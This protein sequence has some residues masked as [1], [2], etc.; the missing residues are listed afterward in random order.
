MKSFRCVFAVEILAVVLYTSHAFLPT[1]TERT[2]ASQSHDSITE[3]SIL[4]IVGRLLSSP[5]AA[6]YLPENR[7]ILASESFTEALRKLT[8]A[9]AW[10]DF[11][12]TA[13]EDPTVHFND[14][15]IVDAAER[16]RQLRLDVVITMDI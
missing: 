6:R 8:D 10:P 5:T 4:I 2:G 9:S 1:T 7:A 11:D 15:R 12:H 13:A 16:L 3:R 14:E